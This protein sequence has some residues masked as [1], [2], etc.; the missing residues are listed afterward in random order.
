MKIIIKNVRLA[1][2]SL[3][4]ATAPATGGEA[5]FSASFLLPPTH[6]QFKELEAAILAT[7]KEKW[8]V[9][10]DVFL[11]ALKSSD[12][13]CLHNGDAKSDYDGFEGNFYIS[14]RS[15]TR[16]TVI[17]GDRTPLTEED[18]KPYA[19]CYVDANIEIWAQDNNFGKRINAQLRGV[20]YRGKGDAFGGGSRPADIEEFDEIAV[21]NED[22][23]LTA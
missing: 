19:G 17:D 16:P 3:W 12:K 10:A 8:G 18:G 21:E 4:K 23:A 20:Q 6:P 14:S 15:K 5:A 1:F 7:A 2:P 11:K 13:T 9:K 22:D